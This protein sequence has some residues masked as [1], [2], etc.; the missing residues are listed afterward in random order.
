M[1]YDAGPRFSE[2]FDTGETAVVPY[3]HARGVRRIDMLV[4]SH[5][6]NDHRGG[7]ESVLRAF[8]AAQVLSSAPDLPFASD[9]CVAGMRWSWDGIEF[10]MM[11]PPLT[12]QS[13]RND[14]SCVLM[15]RSR[16]GSI[17]LPGDIEK[18]VERSLVAAD[19]QRLRAQIVVA[20]HH[21]SKTSSGEAFV[22]AVQARHVLFAVGYRNRYRH[23][24]PTVV[25]RYREAGA[26]L[27]DSPSGGALEFKLGEL[28]T[29]VTSFR[30]SERRYWFSQ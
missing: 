19:A 9:P 17:L 28:G 11:H 14:N 26:T 30:E 5:A 18:R 25:E 6:D 12:P 10:E 22:D 4:I 8:P 7:A 3:L 15:I 21:G 1:V 20:P 24:H 13:R 23:P 2:S 16:H 29:R 27:H